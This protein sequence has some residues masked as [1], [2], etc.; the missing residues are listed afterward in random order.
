MRQF[1]DITNST[2]MVP[3]WEAANCAPTKEFANILWNPKFHCRFH[4]SPPLV[5]IISQTNSHHTTTFYLSKIHFNII[6]PHTS[7]SILVAFFI[8]AL[9]QKSYMQASP[10]PSCYMPCP[11][12]SHWLRHSNY[13]WRR[14]QVMKRLIMQ[15]PPTSC[16]LI[17]VWSKYSPQYPFL[18]HPQPTFLLYCQRPSFTPSLKA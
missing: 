17:R 1:F 9:P 6:H 8:P 3:S 4:K 15:F 5:H 13:T 14:V 2:E 11:S 18:K 10:P 12:H 7:C 16:R